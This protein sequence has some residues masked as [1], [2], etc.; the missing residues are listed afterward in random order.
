MSDVLFI[1]PEDVARFT[2]LNGNVDEDKYIQYI[3]IAQDIH[4][5]NYLGESLFEKLKEDII[6]DTLTGFYYS[7]VNAHLKYMLL[8]WAM[9]E[10]LPFA[11]YSISNKG[12]FK[13]TSEN[14]E[15]VF[16]SEVE[17]LVMKEKSVAEGY[18]KKMI[19]FIEK[20]IT[21]FPEYEDNDNYE[22]KPD[23]KVNYGGWYL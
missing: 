15:G 16:K 10:Y 8:H 22:R 21:Q 3:K 20:N 5:L 18:T 14:A 12:V 13:H 9:V 23:K 7:L 2:S 6:A 4:A 1:K 17:Y 11:S 19:T